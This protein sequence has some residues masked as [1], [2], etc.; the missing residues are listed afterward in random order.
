MHLRRIECIHHLPSFEFCWNLKGV[1]SGDGMVVV[2]LQCTIP[3]SRRFK[4][5]SFL[6]DRLA[7]TALRSDVGK[8]KKLVLFW[9]SG[10][11]IYFIFRIYV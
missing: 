2:Q 11:F 10:I 4:C 3:S 8:G 7:T 5:H 6:G 1:G 9:E